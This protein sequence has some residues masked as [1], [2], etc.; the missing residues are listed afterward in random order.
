MFAFGKADLV[1]YR[2][3]FVQSYS[4]E[5]ETSHLPQAALEAYNTD[6]HKFAVYGVFGIMFVPSSLANEDNL[7]PFILK[8]SFLHWYLLHPPLSPS[9]DLKFSL[10]YHIFQTIYTVS[11]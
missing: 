9:V 6:S 10:F 3:I 11:Y 5:V 8:D 1:I 4:L 7:L 2:P